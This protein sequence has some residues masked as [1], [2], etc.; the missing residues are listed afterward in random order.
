MAKPVGFDQKVLFEHLDFTAY[1]GR[2]L[3]RKEM[4]EALDGFLRADI[5]G[6][7]SRKNAITMLMKIWFLVPEEH[8]FLRNQ[9]LM[10]LPYL[11][12]NEKLILHWSMSTL[13]Y[14]FFADLIKEMG[15]QLRMQDSVS[16]QLL[17]KKMKALYGERRR[18]EVA[19]SAVLTSIKSWG[20][21]EAAGKNTYKVLTK[22]DIQSPELKKFIAEVL[23]R[24]NEAPIL[25]ID[26]LN[27][28]PYFFPFDYEITRSNL[29]GQSFEITRQ[30]LDTTIVELRN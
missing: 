25:P 9:A 11:K 7:K 21:T 20:I 1:E 22:I 5:K 29:S 26:L 14:P 12:R 18:V 28:H 10:L 16:S 30:G 24:M 3:E 4:Y 2:R 8:V 6:V 19:T 15:L 27:N 17:G 13:A 23:L